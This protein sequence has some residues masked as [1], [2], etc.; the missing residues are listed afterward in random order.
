MRFIN[1]IICEINAL[2]D[3]KSGL[4]IAGKD[5]LIK[6]LGLATQE[7]GVKIPEGKLEFTPLEFTR[8]MQNLNLS[9]DGWDKENK[10]YMQKIEIQNKI[11]DRL[12][13]ILKGIEKAEHQAISTAGRAIRG[14]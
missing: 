9:A 5:D 8:L 2:T 7:L 3:D 1:E 12:M 10:T 11:I 6:K 4:S 13:M 14:G